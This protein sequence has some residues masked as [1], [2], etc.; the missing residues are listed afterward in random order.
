[1][2]YVTLDD[3]PLGRTGRAVAAIHNLR[4]TACDQR[5]RPPE[6]WKTGEVAIRRTQRGA[7]F[8][9]DRG[10]SCVRDKRAGDLSLAHKASQDVP[11][12]L[13]RLENAG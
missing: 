2:E 7:V 3:N 11:V 12:P 1:M 8:E 13:S 9:G 4:S 10:K 5:V 6:H